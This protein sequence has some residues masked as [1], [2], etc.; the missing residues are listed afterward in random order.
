V[1]IENAHY[2]FFFQYYTK[3]DKGIPHL[4]SSYQSGADYDFLVLDKQRP[5]VNPRRSW[6]PLREDEYVCI[7]ASGAVSTLVPPRQ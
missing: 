7:Y 3:Q 2:Q 4:S 5:I 6:V 1:Y